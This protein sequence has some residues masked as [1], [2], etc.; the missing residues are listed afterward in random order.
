M[1]IIKYYIVCCE[2][3]ILRE[4]NAL[5]ILPH[6]NCCR[7]RGK[8]RSPIMLK[9][10]SQRRATPPSCNFMM[11]SPPGPERAHAILALT[12]RRNIRP[13]N[14]DAARHHCIPE[15]LRG[16]TRLINLARNSAQN[17]ARQSCYIII[18]MAAYAGKL[19]SS[20]EAIGR[21]NMLC[22]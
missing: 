4:I 9:I 15:Y 16:I 12:R 5:E 13:S 8:A 3:I 7:A 18:D 14:R 6:E 20:R 10:V 19:I 17:V 21:G 22:I 1:K 11:V 2:I